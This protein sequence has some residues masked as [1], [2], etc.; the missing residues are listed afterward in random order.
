MRLLLDTHIW[1]WA[2][3]EPQRLSPAARDALE[4]PENK[5]F[6]SALSWWEF[7]LAFRKGRIQIEGEP[8]AWGRQSMARLGLEV[9][10]VSEDVAIE[11]EHL[12]GFE[13]QDPGDRFIVATA[14]IHKLQ[15]VTADAWIL[16]WPGVQVLW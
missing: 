4:N 1:L 8:V 15:V 2:S 6:I 5:L 12:H 10:P 13:R 3:L 16:Q 7:L 11:V 9:L 14:R